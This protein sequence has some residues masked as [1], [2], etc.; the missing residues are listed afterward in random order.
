MR[1]QVTDLRPA[2][3]RSIF[4]DVGTAQTAIATFLAV[5]FAA[6]RAGAVPSCRITNVTPMNFGAHDL[7][8]STPLDSTGELAVDCGAQTPVQIIMGRGLSG[9]QTPREMAARGISLFYNLFLDAARTIAW[10]DGTEGTQ[11]FM[12]IVPAQQTLRLPIFGR[13]FPRQLVP[14]GIYMDR[15][16]AVAI[17]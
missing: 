8:S 11:T 17:F 6:G 1:A 13:V 16:I 5:I 4:R 10:G 9:H 3:P 14:A 7:S 2:W 12:G 15:I